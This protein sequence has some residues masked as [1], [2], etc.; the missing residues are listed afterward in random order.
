MD[1]Y[2][3]SCKTKV[4][5]Y[6]KSRDEKVDEYIKKI[7]LKVIDYLQTCGKGNNYIEVKLGFKVPRTKKK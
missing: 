1:K 7:N 6:I 5:K 3:K 4:S 2:I